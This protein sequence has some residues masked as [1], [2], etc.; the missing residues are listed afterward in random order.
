MRLLTPRSSC[1]PGPQVVKV[2]F[3]V[4]RSG[5][6]TQAN[7]PSGKKKSG[8]LYALLSNQSPEYSLPNWASRLQS[9]RL[10]SDA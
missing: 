6:K 4:G 1:T 7:K 5:D 9:S 2:D 8:A 3:D 10:H